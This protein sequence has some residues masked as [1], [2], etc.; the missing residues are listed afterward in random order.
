MAQSTGIVLAMGGIVLANTVL[1]HNQPLNFK[2]PLAIGLAAVGF[3]ALERISPDFAV[4]LAWIALVTALIAPIG[5]PVSPLE[6]I[7][8]YTGFA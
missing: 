2:V 5:A 8:K 1:V 4:G 7:L 6:S 3:A